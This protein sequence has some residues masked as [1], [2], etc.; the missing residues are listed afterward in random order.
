[1]DDLLVRAILA[2]RAIAY[3]LVDRRLAV[4]EVGGALAAFPDLDESKVG[5]SL[6]DLVP[7]L[8]GSE[9]VLALILDGELPNFKLERLNRERAGG[10]TYYVDLIELPRRDPSG[11]VVGLVHMVQDVTETGRLEQALTQRRNELA[12]LQGQLRRSNMVLAA[13]NTE[14]RRLDELKTQFISVA[15]HELRNPLTSILGYVEMFLDEDFGPLSDEQREYLNVVWGAGRR[16]LEITDDL[17]DVTRIE[18]GRLDLVLV[19]LDLGA[20][21][22][23]VVAEHR[24]QQEA[25]SQQL[26][27]YLAPGLPAALCDE[28]RTA[29]VVA[30]LLSNACKYTPEGGQIRVRVEPAPDEGFLMVSVADTGMGISA[31]DQPKLFNR[32]YRTA[33]AR[34]SGTGGT[35]LGLY[36]TRS[37]VELQGG[38]IWLESEVGR[39]STFYVTLAQADGG[40]PATKGSPMASWPSS[41]PSCSTSTTTG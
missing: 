11:Q 26:E 13:A 35:G 8:I 2:E 32:F 20:L 23:R 15:S 3:A 33:G 30:N 7:E 24:P 6:V 1:M 40:P 17:L 39:G 10:E 22:G 16:L 21:V 29:Q 37:L 19:P 9:E 18:A 41:W 28:V 34:S 31:E 38:R 5:A 12:L 27:L 25:K 14:L 4:T 36:V